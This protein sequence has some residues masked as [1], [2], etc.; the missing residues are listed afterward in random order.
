MSY[1]E[2]SVVPPDVLTAFTLFTPM[3]LSLALVLQGTM[4]LVT[5]S[6][7]KGGFLTCLSFIVT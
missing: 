3:D 5:L 1:Q 4:C 7:R 6:C 2:S